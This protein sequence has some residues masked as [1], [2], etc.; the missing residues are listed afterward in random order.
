MVNP[1]ET[2][3]FQYLNASYVPSLAQDP[4]RQNSQGEFSPGIDRVSN[5]DNPTSGTI[6]EGKKVTECQTCKNRK[7][8]DGS[9]DPTVSFK[10]P[11]SVSPGAEGYAVAA[12]ENQH[13]MHERGKA[14]QEGREVVSQSVQIHTSVCP[15]CG[16]VFVSGGKT[17]TVT[18][19]K[20]DYQGNLGRNLDLQV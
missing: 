13:V 15:E 10:T 12:H 6:S 5:K 8:V 18:R 14:Q 16:R 20:P 4:V 1:T 19:E 2:N 11:T 7:Y 9:G 17:T 3:Y